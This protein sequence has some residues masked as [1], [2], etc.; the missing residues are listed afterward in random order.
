MT[1]EEISNFI[2]NVKDKT[3][4]AAERDLWHFHHVTDIFFRGILEEDVV[5]EATD[6]WSETYESWIP[7]SR[8][9]DAEEYVNQIIEADKI[10]KAKQKELEQRNI[11]ENK[12]RGIKSAISLLE[13]EGYKVSK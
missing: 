12:E 5:W 6:R 10:Y 11:V 13:M 8:I 2:K 3:K 9:D 7:L 1:T 4:K